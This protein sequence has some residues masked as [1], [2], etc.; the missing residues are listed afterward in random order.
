MPLKIGYTKRKW[1]NIYVIT[2][3]HSAIKQNI[4]PNCQVIDKI[5]H[6]ENLINLIGL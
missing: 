2:S 5:L 4:I 3:M 1:V 6:F